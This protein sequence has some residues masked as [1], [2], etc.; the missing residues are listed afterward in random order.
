M[1][2]APHLIRRI[3]FFQGTIKSQLASDCGSNITFV[4]K[5]AGQHSPA[6]LK[7]YGSSGLWD[8]TRSEIFDLA[9]LH[10]LREQNS[11]IRY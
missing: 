6:S 1:K 7:R 9:K 11:Y 10:I 3:H 8:L 5:D 4:S 2:I